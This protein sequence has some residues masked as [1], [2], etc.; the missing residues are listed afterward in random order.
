MRAYNLESFGD[1]YITRIPNRDTSRDYDEAILERSFNNHHQIVLYR[2][3][4]HIKRYDFFDALCNF[5]IHRQLQGQYK[6]L[7]WTHYRLDGKR[8][9]ICDKDTALRVINANVV[10]N[11]FLTSAYCDYNYTGKAGDL[12]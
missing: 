2:H 5:I 6:D 8:L 12:V 11:W 1:D 4:V 3:G 10:I 9:Y 7:D